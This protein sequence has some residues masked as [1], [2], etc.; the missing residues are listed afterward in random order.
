MTGK[1]TKPEIHYDFVPRPDQKPVLDYVRGEMAISAVPGA[2]KTKILEALI[3]KLMQI[4]DPERLLVLTYMDSA[5]RNIRDRINNSCEKLA[6]FPCISTIHSLAMSII[7]DND[8]SAR[9]N[10]SSDFQICDD[11]FRYRIMTE[12]YN[13][14][15]PQTNI[16]TF[17][18]DVGAAI[19]TIKQLGIPV[20]EAKRFLTGKQAQKYSE[21]VDFLPLYQEYERILKS[22]NMIDFDDILVFSVKLLKEYPEIQDYYRQKFDYIMEDEA[23]DSSALQQELLSLI[24]R[25]NLIRC[26]DP[27]QAITSSF[28]ASEVD[29]FK[30]FI[31]KTKNTVQMTGS[32]RCAKGVYSLANELIDWAEA[33]EELRG[34]FAVSHIQPVP[35]A[36]PDIKN[37]VS[38]DIYRTQQEEKQKVLEEIIKFRK[39]GERLSIGVLLRSNKAVIDWANF[40]EEAGVSCICYSDTIGQKKM[41]RFIKSWLEV[42]NNPW[43]NRYIKDL[44]RDF[45]GENLIKTDFDS[46]HYLDKLGSP[47]I[48]FKENDLP[49]DSLKEFRQHILKW[50]DKSDMSVENLINELGESYFTGVIDRSNT[51]IISLMVEKYRNNETDTEKNIV[52][53]LPEVV[54]Y[55][56]ELAQRKRLGDIRFFEEIE[57]N[58]H[59][60]DFVQLMTVHKAK[61]LEFD[62]VFLPEIQEG[63]FYYPINADNIDIGDRDRLINQIRQVRNKHISAEEIKRQQVHEH[64][65]LIYV[66]ITRA[67]LYLRMSAAEICDKNWVKE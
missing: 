33:R 1:Q 34:A 9:L 67:K 44:Y 28:S 17:M 15:M 36:N 18:N 30:S 64:L 26:G 49:H 22:K 29:N 47:F 25:G 54:E 60:N 59:R 58:E 10:L 23:Q 21:L 7:R 65:R 63:M 19:S 42:L 31:K 37:S 14:F 46:K 55:L 50:L 40:L 8:H 53:T 12:L 4:T 6:K 39:S 24:S 11:A 27:N 48:Y 61:G 41:F 38:V 45:S 3:I 13:L 5:A 35:G 62:V 66:G 57:K 16:G 56:R 43:N 2:G 20:D 52:I 51:R 32:Q